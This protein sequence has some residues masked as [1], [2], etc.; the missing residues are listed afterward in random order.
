M[1]FKIEPATWR[2]L[3]GLRQVENA[4]FDRDAWSLSDLFWVLV[5]PGVARF[6]AVDEAGQ[7]IGFIAGDQRNEPG[8]G[9][10]TTVGVVPEWRGQGVGSALMASCEAAM[11]CKRVRLTV[12]ISNASAIRLYERL[13]YGRV[14]VWRGYYRDGEDG[15]V[16]EKICP[17][18]PFKLPQG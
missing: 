8:L 5:E 18:F 9:W 7:M 2:D 10:I 13:G 6:K 15:V 12:R 16:M 14:E 4:C 3:G 1:T 17:D 11:G